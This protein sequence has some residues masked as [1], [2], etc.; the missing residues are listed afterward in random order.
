MKKH[1]Y[2]PCPEL[3][4]CNALIEKYWKTQ[5]YEKCFSGHLELAKQGYPLAECQVGFF[6]LEGWG[7]E[8]DPA[9]AFY[10]SDRAACH[11]DWDGQYNLAWMYEN[12]VGTEPDA[13]KARQWYRA[14]ALQGHEPAMKKC[15]ECGVSLPE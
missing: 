15:M 8:K 1:V 2:A 14:A 4:Q 6:Y 10:W 13:E 11:G 9:K 3:E 12:G 7:V 5:Q